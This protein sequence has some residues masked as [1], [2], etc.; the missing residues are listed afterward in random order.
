MIIRKIEPD[1]AEL[2]IP[3]FDAYRVF[4]GQDSDIPRARAFIQARL[5]AGESVI[6]AAF[7]EHPEGVLPVGFTQLYPIYS[8]VRTEKNCLLNDLFVAPAFQRQGIG[9]QLIQKAMAFARS[10]GNRSIRL[11][12]AVAN[13]TAQKLYERIGF[14]RQEPDGQFYVYQRLL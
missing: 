1:E 13:R 8:S 4:Y 10:N 9:D 6:F 14:Q 11:E 12:T 2:V 5:H 7:R 3:L